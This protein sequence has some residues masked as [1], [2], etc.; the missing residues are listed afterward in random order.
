[1][2]DMTSKLELTVQTVP[3]SVTSNIDDIC[4]FVEERIKDY[5]P[6]KYIGDIAAARKDRAELVKGAEK[7]ARRRIDIGKEILAP[8]SATEEKAKKAE[9]LIK[10][11][12]AKIDD[13]IESK[14][15]AD[16][17][18]LDGK[19][20]QYYSATGFL[21]VPFEKIKSLY[22]KAD[23]W[24]LAKATMP[25][26]VESLNAR[27]KEIREGIETIDSLGSPESIIQS[28]KI[29][30]LDT[31]DLSAAIRKNKELNEAAARLAAESARPEP[32]VASGAKVMAQAA[33]DAEKERDLDGRRVESLAAAAGGDSPVDDPVFTYGI[34]LTCKRSDKDRFKQWL[35]DN[36]ITFKQIMKGEVYNG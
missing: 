21:L 22:S 12:I 25:K 33:L 36:G 17:L 20:L 4:A 35:I 34:A 1:M 14:E 10:Q 19:L 28:V 13:V 32:S 23:G 30:Y 6:D 29:L 3:V 8:Y 24:Y 31:L 27:I 2:S 18:E 15:E 5:E 9:K 7:I 11:A 16:R 26:V